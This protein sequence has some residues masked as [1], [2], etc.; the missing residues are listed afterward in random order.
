M[1]L[2]LGLA[3]GFITTMVVSV[4]SPVQADNEHGF[5]ECRVDL[6]NNRSDCRGPVE[7]LSLENQQGLLRLDMRKF[8][9]ASFEIEYCSDPTGITVDI[10]DSITNN[11]FGGD[12]ATQSNDAETQVVT[13]SN[14]T[15]LSAFG[16]DGTPT[17]GRPIVT[18]NGVASSGS[19]LRIGVANDHVDWFSDVS[20]A[21]VDSQWLYALA[22]QP[23]TEG[24]VNFDIFAAFNRV[25]SGTPDR[26]GTGV[27]QVTIHLVQRD[28]WWGQF[29]HPLIVPFVPW[30]NER[31][32]Q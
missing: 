1:R 2:A 12:A 18:A 17:Q 13:D 25:V 28:H 30:A 9:R 4:S 23:D 11:G 8:K 26:T 20:S 29:N 21:S 24:P 10:G 14:G 15:T 7:V 27:C 19:L 6:T 32:S 3:T 31:S 5:H 22:G 16:R